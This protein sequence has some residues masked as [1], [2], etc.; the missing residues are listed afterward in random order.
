MEAVAGLDAAVIY[1][2][3]R[4][5]KEAV[6]DMAFAA[7]GDIRAWDKEDQTKLITEIIMKIN[8][9]NACA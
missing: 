9:V 1:S 5:V 7:T 6:R 2:V 8:E 3:T 4:H